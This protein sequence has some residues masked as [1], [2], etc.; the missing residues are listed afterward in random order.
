MDYKVND[1]EKNTEKVKKIIF[2]LDNTILFISNDWIEKYQKIINKYK[3]D[4]SLEELYSSIGN[5]EKNNSDII[6]N[7]DLFIKYINE[8]SSTNITKEI[9]ENLLDDYADITLLYTDVIYDILDYLSQKYEL[10]AYSNWFTENQIKRLKKYNL[11]QFFTKIYGWD[12]LP[13]KPSKRG[14]QEIIKD[15]N[16]EDFIFVGDSIKYDLEVPNSMGMDTIFYNRE[17]INQDKYKEVIS[18]EELKNIL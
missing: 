13:V 17:N 10:I 12:V 16:I 5:V 15:N 14:I 6:I 1:G 3:L 11:E 2:D 18:I 4:I 7:N 8:R 9:L